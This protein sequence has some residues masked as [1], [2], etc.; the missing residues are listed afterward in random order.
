MV[1]RDTIGTYNINYVRLPWYKLFTF[2]IRMERLH[3][4]NE[5]PEEMG[6]VDNK[7]RDRRRRYRGTLG[8]VWEMILIMIELSEGKKFISVYKIWRTGIEEFWM[9]ISDPLSFR[10]SYR[11]WCGGT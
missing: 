10:P 2:L 6:V 7:L 9:A 5:E 3:G 11:N 4:G 1:V 8:V